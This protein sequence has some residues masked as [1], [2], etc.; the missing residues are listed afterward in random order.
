MEGWWWVACGKN[1]KRYL[2]KK[3]RQNF[4]GGEFLE[5]GLRPKKRVA[6]YSGQPYRK[7]ALGGAQNS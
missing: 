1:V 6:K 2:K 5:I 4:V 7:Y 3:G